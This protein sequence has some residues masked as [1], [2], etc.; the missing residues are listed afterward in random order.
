VRISC[1]KDDL[2]RDLQVVA[3]GVSQRSSVQILSGVLIDAP[4]AEQP[5]ELAATDME[6]SVRAKLL[7]DVHEPGRVVV[8]G[9]LLLDIVRHLPPQQ[10]VLSSGDGPG[11]LKLE[12]GA[13]QYSLH[14]YDPDDFPRLPEVDHGRT[15]GVDRET[16]LQAA[17]RVLRAASSDDSR[18]VLTGVLVEFSGG[19][20]TMAA[21]DSYRM[22]VRTTPLEGG[23]PEDLTAIVPARALADLIRIAAA[24]EGEKQLEIVVEDNQVLFGTGDVWLGAR[25]IE[26]QF[27]EFR[28]LLPETFEHEVSLPRAE[29]ADVIARVE[30]LA[31][32][33]PLRL[34]FAPGELTVSAQTQE[35]G[36]GRESLPCDF[37]GEPLEIGFN[38]AFLREGVESIPGDSVVLKLI[39]P[40]R[41]GLLTGG[42]DDY[43]YLIMP[44]RLAS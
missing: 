12:C 5:V 2:L 14:T 32:R 22:A 34:A 41:P 39:T 30:V 8:P 16:F 29:F 24:V 26:G 21:T 6:L 17:Q 13:S 25:R 35:V 4:S 44:I 36:E 18:P 3:R 19:V 31:G 1:P 7:A 33:S 11:L 40:L 15:F 42:T 27:P 20:L 38:P 37:R 9:R 43:W 10:V 23:P 28:R